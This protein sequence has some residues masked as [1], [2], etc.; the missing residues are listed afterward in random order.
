VKFETGASRIVDALKQAGVRSVFGLPGTQT[1]ELFEAL[2][3]R[4][5][6]TVVATNELS[7]AFMAGGWARVTGQPG[8]LVTISGPGF[9][10]ALTGVAEARLD[11]VPLLHI[12]GSPAKEAVKRAFRQ[13]EL[14]QGEVA[15]PLVKAIFD[16]DSYGDPAHSVVD[17][18]ECAQTGEPGPVLLQVS[19]STLQQTVKASSL[20]RTRQIPTAHDV[21][22]SVHERVRRSRRCVILAGQGTAR[23]ADSLREL[24]LRINVPVITTPSARGVIPEDHRLNLGFNPLAGNAQRINE[25]LKTADLVLVIG[26]KLSHSDTSGF[27]IELPPERLIHFDS[28]AEVIAANYPTSLGA[29][30]DAGDLFAKLLASDVEKSSWTNEELADWRQKLAV[31]DRPTAEPLVEGTDTGEASAFFEALRRAL[32]SETILV[33]DSGLHQILARRYYKVLAP[34]GLL[35]PTDL[36]SMGFAIPTAIGARLGAPR[37]PVVALIGDGGFAMTALELLTAVR[38]KIS[39]TVIVFVDGAFGQI[40]MQ[41]LVNYGASHGATIKNPDFRLLTLSLGADYEEVAER[42]IESVVAAAINRRGV[43]VIGVGVRDALPIRRIA[44]AA[45][46]RETARRGGAR[47]VLSVLAKLL[48]RR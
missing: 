22:D 24:V 3:R 16:A 35:M 45:R 2:R 19:A 11:S 46:V 20:R 14:R 32:P 43:T 29:V 44:V 37:R 4:G 26:C 30:G 38:E 17:A 21:L 25:F 28:S 42:D 18:F 12:S 6:R 9:T 41:Q 31:T 36:Q 27:E 7:A 33:L 15:G 40:R 48:R 8:V 23:Y 39:L 34:H 10:W 1:I 5:L 47:R 13:Q